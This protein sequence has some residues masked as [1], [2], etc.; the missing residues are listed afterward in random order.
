LSHEILERVF[1]NLLA[2]F[3]NWGNLEN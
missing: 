1:L 3:K 2:S